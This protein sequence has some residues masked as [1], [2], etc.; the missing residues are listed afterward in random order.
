MDVVNFTEAEIVSP[1]D[2]TAIGE[3]SREAFDA[4]DQAA[5]G[6]PAHWARITVSNSSSDVVT[7]SSGDYYEGDAVYSSKEV[8]TVNLQSFKPTI[9]SDERWMALILRGAEQVVQATRAFETGEEPLTESVPVNQSTPKYVRR[10][11]SVVT[12]QGPISPAPA[13]V[14]TIA[15]D[16]CCIAFVRLKTTGIVEIVSNEASRVKSVFEIEGRLRVVELQISTIFKEIEAI[17]TNLAAVAAAVKLVPPRE[18]ISQLTNDVSMVRQ[19]LNFPAAARNYWFNQALVPDD[20]DLGHVDS[21]ARI[22][23]GVRFQYAQQFLQTME[24]VNPTNPD[25]R[26]I[27]DKFVLPAFTETLRL[28]SPVG[29]GRQDISNTVH[30]VRTAHTGRRSTTLVRYGSTVNVCENTA[31]WESIGNRRAGEIFSVSG[32]EYVSTGQTSNPWN[33]TELGQNGHAQYGVRSVIRDTIT[34]TY[35][36]YTTEEF[37]LNGAIFAQT[38]LN[39]QMMVL[40]SIDLYFTRVGATGDV[41]LALCEINP[42]GTPNYDE[43]ITTVNKPVGQIANGWNKFT[44]SPAL[45]EPGKRYAW[46]TVT[47]GNHQIAK[48]SGNQFTGGTLFSSSDGVWSQGSTT[49]DFSFRLYAAKFAKSRV[50]IEMDALQ[51]ADGMTEIELVYEGWEPAG[52]AR[53]WQ[54]QPYGTDEWIDLDDRDPNPLANLPPLVRLRLV[55]IGTQDLAPMIVM[56]QYTKQLTG[57]CRPDMQALS[58]EF[59]LGFTTT[60]LQT[61]TNVDNFDPAHHTFAPKIMIGSTVYTPS[62]TAVVVDPIK[63]KRRKVTANFTVPSTGVARYRWDMNSDNVVDMP[64]IQ[65]VQ[66]NF[67]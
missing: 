63:P 60:T 1:A 7:V 19:Q 26:I 57:R 52:T 6:W 29:A 2:L 49:E 14:P 12:Q 13:V 43:I 16:D 67:Y 22:R 25:I 56:D 8:L 31:G 15:E 48:N 44:F 58:D 66:A 20:W 18:L 41:R 4:R 38:F 59:T 11:M 17:T 53:V 10:V 28:E 45:L 42:D 21:I 46:F 39:A 51:L 27:E 47:T 30:T 32:R 5:L 61:V 34:T 35:T 3:F 37:G 65:D 55:M 9:V 50:E 23:E 33:Q 64:F 54:I 24:I 40:S 36:Y 62:S